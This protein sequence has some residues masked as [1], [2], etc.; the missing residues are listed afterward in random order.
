MNPNFHVNDVT[1]LK[2]IVEAI[3]RLNVCIWNWLRRKM[4]NTMSQLAGVSQL[5]P[6]VTAWHFMVKNARGIPESTEKGL[7]VK[8]NRF[9]PLRG[10][11]GRRPNPYS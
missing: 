7:H 3:R 1:V 10:A 5:I 8:P 4:V 11:I 6:E 9:L 2:K